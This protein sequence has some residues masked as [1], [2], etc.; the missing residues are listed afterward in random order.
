M[1]PGAVAS[2]CELVDVSHTHAAEERNLRTA[3]LN[4]HAFDASL[5]NLCIECFMVE[6]PSGRLSQFL[7][8]RA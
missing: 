4:V 2:V 5:R 1:W 6:I 3:K 7:K 8:E